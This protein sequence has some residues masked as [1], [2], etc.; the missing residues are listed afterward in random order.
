M[1]RPQPN[2][3]KDTLTFRIEPDMKAA[4]DALA[5]PGRDRSYIIKSMRQSM[6]IWILSVAR[7]RT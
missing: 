4:L 2:M 3:P 6:P 1:G 5:A 7:L